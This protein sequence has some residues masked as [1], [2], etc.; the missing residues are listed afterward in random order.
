[1]NTVVASRRARVLALAL[2]ALSLGMVAF[3][4][5]SL[6]VPGAEALPSRPTLITVL[7]VTCV[8]LA[9]PLVG[10]LVAIRRPDNPIGWLFVVLGLGF[11]VGYFSTE[12]IGRAQISG[13]PLP[14]AVLVGWVGNWSFVVSMGLAFAWIPLLFPTG[15]LPGPRWRVVAW[16]LVATMTLGVASIALRPGLLDATN[17]GDVANP[18]GVP[19]LAGILSTIDAIYFPAIAVL[20]FICVG[21]LFVRFRASSAVE[22]QQIKWL[23]LATASFIVA[24]GAALAIQGE[25]LFL[26]ALVAAAGIPVSAGIAILR[27]RLW[28]IDRLVS[29]SIGWAVVTAVLVAIFAV[30]VV[31]LQG[32][33]APITSENTLAVAA[34]TL[35]ACA[36][37]QPLRRRVQLAVDRRFDRS[38]HD[39]ERTATAFSASLRDQVVLEQITHGTV[40]VVG[41]TVRPAHVGLWLR[42]AAR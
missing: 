41:G 35:L 4:L 32:L 23:M 24:L 25:A 15:H 3:A 6:V 36:L 21:S 10:T 31:T 30:V 38:R 37:F 39:G 5:A 9:Y 20:G 12:Y 2:F 28:D 22:R 27:Y 8:L 13:W 29:R 16:A 11:A 1:M 19:G 17:F 33:L 7:V 42:G 18:F 40:D 26:L 34:S 14:G